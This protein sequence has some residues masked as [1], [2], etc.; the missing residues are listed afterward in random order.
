M[1]KTQQCSFS[2]C[3]HPACT[4]LERR[5]LCQK[6]FFGACYEGLERWTERLQENLSD[7]DIELARHFASE[8]VQ[9]TAAL[10]MNRT[11]LD[12]LGRAQLLDIIFWASD[13]I[14]R[15]RR[16]PRKVASVRVRLRWEKA[17]SVWEEEAETRVLSRYGALVES[18][19]SLETG[20]TLFV[21]R[22]DT[23]RRTQARVVW[24]RCKEPAKW[25][26]G[27][28]FVDCDNFWQMD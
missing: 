12:N 26:I 17:G 16:S 27:I 10:A 4:L 13:I 23:G 8:C 14:L 6:H 5:S 21:E 18:R 9:Q 11:D 1:T 3:D 2:G 24:Q 7:T 22:L 15:L 20:E 25:E 19:Y 28:E